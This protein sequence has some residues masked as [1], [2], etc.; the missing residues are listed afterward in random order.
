MRKCPRHSPR[1]PKTA[2][3]SVSASSS[4]LGRRDP[5]WEQKTI[6]EY[7]SVVHRHRS[8]H[9]AERG[10]RL[11]IVSPS[12]PRKILAVPIIARA[13]EFQWRRDRMVL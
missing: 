10:A 2:E 8:R 3:S 7:L 13:F 5:R 9:D 4:V 1:R 11:A 12:D 6:T